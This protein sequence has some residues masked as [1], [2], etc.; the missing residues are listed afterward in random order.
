MHGAYSVKLHGVYFTRVQI[1][2][3]RFGNIV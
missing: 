1:Y 3:T 2:W